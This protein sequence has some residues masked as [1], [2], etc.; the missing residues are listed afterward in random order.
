MIYLLCDNT[1]LDNGW[2]THT[3]QFIRQIKKKKVIIICRKKNPKLKFKQIEILSNPIDYFK[4]PLLIIKDAYKLNKLLNNDDPDSYLHINVEPYITLVPFLKKKFKKVIYTFHGSY[5]FNLTFSKL[6]F[7][8]NLGLKYS[9]KIIFVSNYTKKKILP[10]LKNNK[11][12]K[13]IVIKNGI[14]VK[15]FYL[16]KKN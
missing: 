3:N 2:G 15:Q 1:N 11:I 6:K 5:F 4:N 8:F 14:N 10:F 9:T 13:K 7:F 12:T 16:K